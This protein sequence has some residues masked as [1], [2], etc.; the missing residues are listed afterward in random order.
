MCVCVCLCVSLFLSLSHDFW[1]PVERC[2]TNKS[3][4]INGAQHLYIVFLP[5][6]AC[7]AKY[8][9]NTFNATLKRILYSFASK[10]AV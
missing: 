4:T 7:Y 9:F 1:F 3:W 2:N 8:F 10:D 5:Y 6:K